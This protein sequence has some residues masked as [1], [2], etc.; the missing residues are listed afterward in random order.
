[1]NH[2]LYRYGRDLNTHDLLKIIATVLMILDHVG[3]VMNNQTLRL[4]GRGAAPIFY[5][6][7]G[8]SGK[9]RLNAF[10]ALYGLILS[11]TWT[12]I[13]GSYW[14]N[15]LLTFVL[16]HCVLQIIDVKKQNLVMRIL[17]FALLAYL[18]WPVY[19]YLEYGFLGLL[20]AF[21]GRL[22]ALKERGAFWWLATS[23]IIFGVFQGVFI[24][25]FESIFYSAG[26]VAVFVAVFMLLLN[27]RV[28]TV[29]CARQLKLAALLISR[30]SLHIY[31]Y[32]LL[33][34]QLVFFW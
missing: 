9:L 17:G 24:H 4:L 11:Y 27:H 10:I 6:L 3:V 28:T 26:L 25:F 22:L 29:P 1:M 13:S 20:V 14:V 31:F 8:Y 16:I 30:Y 33:F 19:R 18:S 23:L 15:I 21:A 34:I 2:L 7:I 32:H 12:I 5:F